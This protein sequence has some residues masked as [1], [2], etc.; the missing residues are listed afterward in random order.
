MPSLFTYQEE[1]DEVYNIEVIAV[2]N[3]L[4]KL[5]KRYSTRELFRKR[6]NND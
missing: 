2:P 4:S 5:E 6:Q 3:F 1:D